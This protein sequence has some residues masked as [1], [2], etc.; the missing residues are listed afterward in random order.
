MA[1]VG[2]HRKRIRPHLSEADPLFGWKESH[3]QEQITWGSTNSNRE[4]SAK[5][6]ATPSAEIPYAEIDAAGIE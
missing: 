3:H 5:P 4:K 6:C 1:G 2:E